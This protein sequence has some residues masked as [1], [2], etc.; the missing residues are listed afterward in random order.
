[1]LLWLELA[2]TI[3]DPDQVESGIFLEPIGSRT[4][5]VNPYPK[6]SYLNKADH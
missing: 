2:I 1:M 4:G 6:P 5:N 3:A